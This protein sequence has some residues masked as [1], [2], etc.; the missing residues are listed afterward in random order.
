MYIK[1]WRPKRAAIVMLL[2]ALL[3]VAT[4]C[5]S[6]A[7]I[8]QDGATTTDTTTQTSSIIQ[9]IDINVSKIEP[10]LGIVFWLKPQ[11]MDLNLIE[12][13]GTADITLWYQS[14]P[15]ENNAVN[16]NGMIQ[17]WKNVP[18][19]RDMYS[20]FLGA[21]IVLEYDEMVRTLK[22]DNIYG[23][24]GVSLRLAGGEI[25]TCEETYVKISE[26]YSC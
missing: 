5:S 14:S 16:K 11:D 21:S 25:V 10:S 24:L 19:T 18:V 2:P 8:T 3:I 26:K 7:T 9:S 20:P 6:Q 17:E 15:D 12:V 22:L 13:E 4:T 1:K 23:I